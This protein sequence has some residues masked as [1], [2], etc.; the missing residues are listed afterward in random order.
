[1]NLFDML[2]RKD[3]NLVLSEDIVQTK[4]DFFGRSFR[5]LRMPKGSSVRIA[6]PRRFLPFSRLPSTIG[7]FGVSEN[8][9]GR[10]RVAYE[11]PDKKPAVIDMKLGNFPAEV[12]FPLPRT[13]EAEAD[14][15]SLSL[16]AEK[17]ECHLLV[18]EVFDRTRLIGACRGT[19]VELGPGHQPQIRP[20]PGVD[21]RYV[22]QKSVESWIQT[23][24]QKSAMQIDP[25]L[26]DRYTIG[27]AASIPVADAELDFIFS[28]HVLEH[29]INPLRCLEH[30]SRKLRPGGIV[31]CVVPDAMGCK[32]Y[33]FSLSNPALWEAEYANDVTE[34]SRDHFVRYAAGSRMPAERVDTMIESG[35]SIHV[36]FYSRENI[37]FLLQSC[38]DRGWFTRYELDF[39]PNNKDFHL[40]LTR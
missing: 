18:N 21:V 12:F 25:A 36:H 22:E 27:S 10:L 38:V 32:D 4:R 35:F 2:R 34:P 20:G 26:W 13:S 8:G 16:V 6:T 7:W 30:W 24:D 29:L 9:S 19:G 14:G 40:I 15:A 1:M 17:A 11:A 33:V 3:R 37:V 31:A 39:R 5:A 23:Y 28:S